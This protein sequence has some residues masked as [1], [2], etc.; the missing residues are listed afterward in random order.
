MK[1]MRI[2][3]I[4]LAAVL[5]WVSDQWVFGADKPGIDPPGQPLPAVW[6]AD[7]NQ[8]P[9]ANRPLQIIHG[10]DLRAALAEGVEQMVGGSSPGQLKSEPMRF[11]KDRGLGGVVCNVAF[12]GYMDSEENWKNLVAGVEGC[13]R[14]GMVVWIYD[15][16]GYP[17]GAAGGQVLRE[18]RA[19]EAT[20]L[21]FDASRSDPL[22]IRAAYEHT[23]ASNNYYAARRSACHLFA[24]ENAR[25]EAA[26][27]I[28]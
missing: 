23:H 19:W 3:A 15:E 9:M 21:A 24:P 7:W 6:L 25:R 10:I 18:N 11:Y 13:D 4:G 12:R 20:E 5:G 14:L 27:F 26:A 17:S 16:Q 2:W 8:P 28:A 1:L 22:L